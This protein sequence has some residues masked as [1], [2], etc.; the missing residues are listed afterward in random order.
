MEDKQFSRMET[1]EEEVT[2]LLYMCDYAVSLTTRHLSESA[3]PQ[4]RISACG[5]FPRCPPSSHPHLTRA[6]WAFPTTWSRLSLC[7]RDI[8]KI[9]RAESS[10]C[11]LAGGKKNVCLIPK[12]ELK[13]SLGFSLHTWLSFAV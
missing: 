7:V 13:V 3:R 4:T 5:S 8:L 9:R 1:S 6:K 12:C 11:K 10:A 2:L